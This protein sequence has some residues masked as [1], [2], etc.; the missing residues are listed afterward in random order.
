MNCWKSINVKKEYNNSRL[1]LLSISGMVVCFVISYL[2]FSLYQPNVHYAEIGFINTLLFLLL[3]FP[4]H[5]LLDTIP[6]W[7]AGIRM[8]MYPQH[9]KSKRLPYITLESKKPVSRNVYMIAVLVPTLFIGTFSL[10][11]AL[12]YPPYM[13]LFLVLFSFNMGRSIYDFIYIKPLIKAPRHAFIEQKQNGL[14]ILL[15]QPM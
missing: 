2:I 9:Y 6:L 11:G 4:L 5:M 1:V 8:K 10:L 3:L 12:L 13:H 7:F 15:K 14:D